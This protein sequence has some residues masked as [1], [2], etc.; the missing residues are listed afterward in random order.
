VAKINKSMSPVFKW[1]TWEESR[2]STA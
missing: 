1:P 2:T